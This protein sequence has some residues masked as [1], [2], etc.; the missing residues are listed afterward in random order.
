MWD[1]CGLTLES[2]IYL[3]ELYAILVA[4]KLSPRNCNL[5]IWCDNETI[6]FGLASGGGTDST[7]KRMVNKFYSMQAAKN[8]TAVVKKVSSKENPA[9]APSRNLVKPLNPSR[10][11]NFDKLFSEVQNKVTREEVLDFWSRVF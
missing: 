2:P 1:K 7:Y 4:L 9:D 5:R 8:I 3:K 10:H 6:I 11:Q